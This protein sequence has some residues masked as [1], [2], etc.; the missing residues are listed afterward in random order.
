MQN[1]AKGSKHST[2][3]MKAK[4]KSRNKNQ[5]ICSKNTEPGVGAGSQHSSSSYLG[6]KTL[7]T[8]NFV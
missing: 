4:Y 6:F 7:Y 3:E 1:K 8:T 2:N 5:V